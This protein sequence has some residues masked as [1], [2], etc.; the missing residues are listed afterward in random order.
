MELTTVPHVRPEYTYKEGSYTVTR[1]SAWSG[2][3]CHDGCGV[4]IYTD[5]DGKLIKVEGDPE[6]PYNQGRLCVRCLAV[7]DVVNSPQ[8][9]RHPMKRAREDRG[10]NT[11]QE[12]SWD[13]AFDLIYDEFTAIK[14]Q[15]GP[16][17]IIFQMGTGRDI[18]PWL[19]RL[20]YSIGSPNSVFGMSGEACYTTRIIGCIATAGCFW[21]GDYAQQFMDRYDNPNWKCPDTVVLWGN[22][23]LIANSDGMFGHWLIDVMKRGAKIIQIDPRVNWLSVKADLFLRIRPGSD[24]ALA[25]GMLNVIIQED[26][27]DH[28]FVDYW[29]H[30]FEE[31]AEHV[32]PWTLERVEEITWVPAEKIVEAARMIAKSDGAILQWGVALDMTKE[33]LPTSQAAFLIFC[34]TGQIDRPGG[35]VMPTEIIRY[36]GGWGFDELISKEIDKKRC[37]YDHYKL[38]GGPMAITHTD[39][40]IAQLETDDPYRIA[41]AWIQTTNFLACTGPDP[42][43]TL[44]AYHRLDFV[45]AVDMFMTPTIM[46]IADVVLPVSCF[47]EKDGLRVGDGFQRFETINRASDQG[48]TKSDVQINLELG[49]RFN[50]EAWPWETDRDV[51]T[52]VI[53]QKGGLNKTFEEA[54]DMAPAYQP[55]E[56]YR[57]KSGKL[58]ADGQPGFNTPTGR[59][60]LYSTFFEMWDLPPLPYFEEPEPSPYSTPELAKKYPYIL[61]TGA[62]NWWSFHSEHRQIP[63]LRSHHPWP[64]VEL[65]PETAAENGLKD[66]DW[67]WVENNRGRCKRMVQ[68]TTAVTP[69]VVSTDHGWW[70]PE[71]PGALDDGLFGMWDVDVNQLLRWRSGDAGLGSN[72][73]TTI[74][75]VYKV[76]PGD[77]HNEW[78]SDKAFSYKSEEWGKWE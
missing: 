6:N 73:K 25:L 36:A 70:L 7:Q 12:C 3:G 42:Q 57:Y 56:Y 40:L 74:C 30:G 11:W 8:R 78:T 76:E 66:G 53:E 16:E 44:A 77:E 10:K 75:R 67:C 55:F 48:D 19:T 22:N 24:A 59:I 28:E 18:N 2:P 52:A 26:L 47:T 46:A 15:Y 23:P 21:V 39:S 68:V 61:T 60:E 51:L 34:I 29:C 50:P 69:R 9:L 62:R 43:R 35:M 1:G 13:E 31:L 20:C 64:V 41:G 63:S 72:Y 49:R 58:R 45:A 33:A 17:S 32:R 54:R 37:G 4:L 14:E 38:L 71:E 65:H 27:Y 5:E